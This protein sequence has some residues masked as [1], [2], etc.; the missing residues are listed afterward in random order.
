MAKRRISGCGKANCWAIVAAMRKILGLSYSELMRETGYSGNTIGN[1]ISK[2]CPETIAHDNR[3]KAI[4][5]DMDAIVR[6]YTS[7]VSS[8]ELA[9]RYDVHPGT[10]S[11]WMRKRGITIGKGQRKRSGVPSKAVERKCK[12]CGAAFATAYQNQLFCSER[13]RTKNMHVRLGDLSGY[14]RR[15][16]HFGV[17]YVS[18]ITLRKIIER[19]GPTCY[20]CG[21]RCTFDDRDG[22]NIGPSYPTLDHV[23]ALSNGGGHTWDNVRVACFLCNVRKGAKPLTEEAEVA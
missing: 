21:R 15:A 19:D 8:Y 18:G 3:D 13:C 20:I 10:I 11:K 4:S 7:G 1:I 9:E 14:R 16:K 5:V 2:R 12:Q 22:C 17:D 23:V 6:E